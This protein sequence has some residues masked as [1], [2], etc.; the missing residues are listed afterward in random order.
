[1]LIISRD[2]FD[3][4]GQ[5]LGSSNPSSV[6]PRQGAGTAAEERKLKALVKPTNPQLVASAKAKRAAE[7]Q[8]EAEREERARVVKR[9]M[10]RK[11]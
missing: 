11:R 9:W 4:P 7:E 2:M 10:N 6:T 5:T 1:M 3:K 8:E